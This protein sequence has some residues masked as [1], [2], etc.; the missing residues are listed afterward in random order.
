MVDGVVDGGAGA[1]AGG[2]VGAMAGG[3]LGAVVGVP[4][5]TVPPMQE[6]HPQ[7]PQVLRQPQL[8]QVLRQPHVPHDPQLDP[9]EVQDDVQHVLQ[10]DWQQLRR[11]QHRPKKA[12]AGS[13]A[14]NHSKANTASTV[15]KRRMTQSS[16]VRKGNTNHR[17]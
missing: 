12:E 1:R 4:G 7:L 6:L 11:P 9:H 16:C 17:T 14:A 3:G 2:A 5:A 13:A 15:P 10:H 8:P